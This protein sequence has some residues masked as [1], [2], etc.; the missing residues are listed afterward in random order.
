VEI[1]ILDLPEYMWNGKRNNALI[2]IATFHS[3]SFPCWR[4][5]VGENCSIETLQ[6]GIDDFL[7]NIVKN[8]FSFDNLRTKNMI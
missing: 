3:K 5:A 2:L 7:G 8:F 1:Y 4:L 6:G